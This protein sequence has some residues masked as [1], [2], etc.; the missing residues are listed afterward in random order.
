M[1]EAVQAIE[2]QFATHVLSSSKH[3]ENL[4]EQEEALT[5]ANLARERLRPTIK[6]T[7]KDLEVM[8]GTLSVEYL[9]KI[10]AL[11]ERLRDEWQQVNK[12]Y[13]ERHQVRKLSRLHVFD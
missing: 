3:Y 9:E 7:A 10:V 4:G 12:K 13:K 1:R 11:S 5:T 6:K 8:T 2:K